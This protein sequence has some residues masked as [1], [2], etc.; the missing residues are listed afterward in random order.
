M[1]GIIKRLFGIEL[2]R[3][4]A[5][6]TTSSERSHL[7]SEER[8]QRRED[9]LRRWAYDMRR[10]QEAMAKAD[11]GAQDEEILRELNEDPLL[12]KPVDPDMFRR[13]LDQRRLQ[14]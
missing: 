4:A 3:P 5:K 7:T 11:E 10:I 9:A 13:L 14:R 1:S 6:K 2:V 8:A 12:S